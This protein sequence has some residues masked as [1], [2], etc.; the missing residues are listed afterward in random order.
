M[1]GFDRDGLE[2]HVNELYKNDNPMSLVMPVVDCEYID[3]EEIS[4]ELAGEKNL[5]DY[6]AKGNMLALNK[7]LGKSCSAQKQ[8]MNGTDF[9]YR[10]C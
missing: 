6:R 8:T 3:N 2:K 5:E 9:L 7:V 1:L 10:I 4:A